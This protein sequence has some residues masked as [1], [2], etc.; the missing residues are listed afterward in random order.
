[1]PIVTEAATI[2]SHANLRNDLKTIGYA[3]YLCE[4]VQELCPENQEHRDIF[5]LFKE[6]LEQLGLTP[7][8][9][10]LIRNFEKQ[11]LISLGYHSQHSFAQL[12]DQADFIEEII[13]KKLKTRH[14][15]NKII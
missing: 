13:E 7:N 5:Y 2:N 8:P 15:F 11:L 3:Y 10:L 1:M 4:L 14:I 9:S 6:T 12:T